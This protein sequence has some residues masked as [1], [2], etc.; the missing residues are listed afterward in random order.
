MVQALVWRGLFQQQPTTIQGTRLSPGH[1][2][3]AVVLGLWARKDSRQEEVTS[4]DDVLCPL[5]LVLWPSAFLGATRREELQLFKL[6]AAFHFFQSA[7]A[8][9]TAARSGNGAYGMLPWLLF[10]SPSA[11]LW[12]TFHLRGLGESSF[13][14]GHWASLGAFAQCQLH[15]G[16]TRIQEQAPAEHLGMLVPHDRIFQLA[17]PRRSKRQSRTL[18]KQHKTTTRTSNALIP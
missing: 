16:P 8:T 4:C 11:N 13:C 15:C 1:F 10:L 7:E 17:N 12:T 14:R 2:P 3:V 9:K 18:D 6:P 5:R